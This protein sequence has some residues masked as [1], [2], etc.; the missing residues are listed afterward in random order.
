MEMSLRLVFLRVT[1]NGAE[2]VSMSVSGKLKLRGET[3]SV[4]GAAVNDVI[5]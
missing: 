1:A 2:V 5:V 4:V 3:L